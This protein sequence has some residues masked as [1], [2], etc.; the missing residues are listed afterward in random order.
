MA[1]CIECG[2]KGLFLKVNSKGICTQCQQS[3]LES[4]FL[5]ANS[6]PGQ[7]YSSDIPQ[8]LS[9][10]SVIRMLSKAVEKS[11]YEVVSCGKVINE[12]SYPQTFYERVDHFKAHLEYLVSIQGVD[13]S[14]FPKVSPT[15]LREEF[16]R[17][18]LFDEEKMWRRFFDQTMDR[19]V[20]LKT[21]RGKKNAISKFFE[22]ADQYNNVMGE[23]SKAAIQNFKR[24]VEMKLHTGD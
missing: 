13:A 5:L 3:R 22:I 11:L 8:G 17:T 14:L 1:K 21:D 18:Y 2:R 24:R 7:V 15:D 12:T 9:P 6:A 4:L 10:Q 19:V 23:P 20:N 16:Y